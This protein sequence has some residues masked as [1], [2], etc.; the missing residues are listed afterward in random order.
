[1]NIEAKAIVLATGCRERPRTARLI[2]GN[3]PQGIFTTGMLQNFV[4]IQHQPVGKRAIVVGAEH[5]SFSAVITLKHTGADVLALITDL[6]CHQSLLQYKL[7]STD[8]YRVPIY[9]DM[10]LT[11]IMGQSRVEA[12]ELT[13]ALDGSVHQIECD[14]V[15]FTGDWIPDYELAF[16]GGLT[17]DPKS[18]APSVNQHLQT[19]RNGVFAVGNLIHAAETADVAALSGR[20]AARHVQ[21][22]LLTGE[23]TTAPSL[24]IEVTEPIAWVSPDRIIPGELV[25]PHGHFILRVT[26]LLDHPTL[27]VWQAECCLLRK[28]YRRLVPNLPV[29]LSDRW[30]KHIDASENP[31]RIELH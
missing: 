12:V 31:I 4:Y 16:Y 22:Y 14:T 6:P 1:M 26:R 17:I 23:W 19:S 7:I 25:V 2:P 30:L 15:V 29:Y 13:H 28:P 11:R 9:T 21:D 27:E 20:Y 8:R 18:K 10:K 5:V 3:R 24:P